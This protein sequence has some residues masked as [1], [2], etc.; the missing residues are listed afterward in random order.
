MSILVTCGAGH[1]GSHA[2]N[3]P[4]AGAT[5]VIVRNVGVEVAGG[6]SRDPA[7]RF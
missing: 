1:P 4:P 5:T 6:R 7:R 3:P 2:V